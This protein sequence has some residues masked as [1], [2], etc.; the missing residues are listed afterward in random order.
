[1]IH[2]ERK[3]VKVIEYATVHFLVDFACVFYLYRY[4]ADVKTVIAAFLVY[5]FCAFAMQM[6][7]G[8]FADWKNRNV[9]I[10]ASGCFLIA[11]SYLGS[12]IYKNFGEIHNVTALVF[13][14]LVGLGNGCFHV[15]AGIEVLNESESKSN[16]LGIFVSPGALG[17]YVGAMFSNKAIISSTVVLIVLIVAGFFMLFDEALDTSVTK[18]AIYREVETRKLE[19]R[20]LENRTLLFQPQNVPLS[21]RY[22]EYRKRLVILIGLIFVV[23][24]RSYLGMIM[25]FPWKDA[26]WGALIVGS[27]VLGK[28]VGG[29]L[30]DWLGTFKASAISLAVA[31][32]FFLLSDKP[33][34]GVLAVLFFNMTMPITLWQAAKVLRKSKGFAFGLLTF[35][36]FL[37]Y[38]PKELT[39]PYPIT[40]Y[41]GY[42][43]LAMIS[44]ILLLYS[45]WITKRMEECR[46][47]TRM[48]RR[49]KSECNGIL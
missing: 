27:V 14:I 15:G 36:L 44:M 10:A 42:A 35:G 49:R 33:I 43:V 23:I 17:L 8:L 11:I 45:I 16:L 2:L 34:F 32:T 20:K 25:S 18:N 47:R 40:T 46:E 5:N 30:A 6:P 29:F 9:V 41:T 21:F 48:K 37:G 26:T 24:L 3:H 1:M 39:F 12:I 13:V 4:L 19:N 31:A 38:L 7:I 22:S 28:M